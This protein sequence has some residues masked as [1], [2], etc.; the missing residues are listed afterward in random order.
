MRVRN[1]KK[2]KMRVGKANPRC[3]RIWFLWW[4]IAVLFHWGLSRS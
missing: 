3:R 4:K 2:V 1:W